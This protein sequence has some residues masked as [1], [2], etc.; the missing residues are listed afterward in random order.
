[1]VGKKWGWF[2]EGLVFRFARQLKFGGRLGKKEWTSL[3]SLSLS[4]CLIDEV[5]GLALCS[6]DFLVDMKE[7][8][9]EK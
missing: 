4:P 6:K 1:M 2:C 3:L 7:K 5:I 8:E 9:K